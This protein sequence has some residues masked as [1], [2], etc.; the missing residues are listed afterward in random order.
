MHRMLQVEIVEGLVQQEKDYLI[1]LDAWRLVS[2]AQ[3]EALFAFM[4]T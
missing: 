4:R 1:V 3:M 2:E